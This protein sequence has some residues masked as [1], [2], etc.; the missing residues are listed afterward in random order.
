MMR[1]DLEANLAIDTVDQG[2]QDIHWDVDD[3]LAVGALQ[4]SV[5][6]RCGLVGRLGHG[7]VV[8]RC[9]ATDVSVGDQPEFP[10]CRQSTIDRSPVNPGSRC[11]G[12]S[13]D[14]VGCQVL[15]GP[16]QNLDDGLAS[17][18]HALVLVAEQVQRGLHLLILLQSGPQ[19]APNQ[20]RRYRI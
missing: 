18:R 4:M 5:R 12:A 6:S 15:L 17:S 9:R 19:P 7:E 14:F 20:L 10:K 3:R 8:D 16:V 11:L 2:I 1:L 13:D